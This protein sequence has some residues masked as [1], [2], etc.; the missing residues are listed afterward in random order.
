[1]LTGN[2]LLSGSATTAIIVICAVIFGISVFLYGFFRK[3]SQMGWLPWQIPLM[4]LMVLFTDLIPD[5]LGDGLRFT[6]AVGI[7]LLGAAVVL[8]VGAIVRHAMHARLRPASGALRAIDRVLGGITALLGLLLFVVALGGGVLAVCYYCATEF[9]SVVYDLPIWQNLCSHAFDFFIVAV[10]TC[11]IQAGYRVGLGRTILT[12]LMLA[13]TVGALALAVY[14]TV[15]VSFFRSFAALFARA[16]PGNAVVARLV[17]MAISILILFIV[18]FTVLA[19][20][21]FFLHKLVRRCRYTGV[22][23]VIDGVLCALLFFAFMLVLACGVNAFVY[24]A[25]SGGL[26]AAVGDNEAVADLIGEIESA[27]RRVVTLFRHS[28][29]A[30]VLYLCNPFIPLLPMG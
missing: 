9:M 11:T 24:W 13:A 20:L 4:F 22:L 7:F 28:Y 15:G 5:T 30:D 19:T 26:R 18:I 25:G 27:M 12:V 29:F 21:G 14:L 6:L 2:L 17:G 8:G 1:M 23:G 10:F 3:F 16:I